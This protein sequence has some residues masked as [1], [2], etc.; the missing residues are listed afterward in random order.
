MNHRVALVTNSLARGGAETQL[1]HLARGLVDRGDE[2]AILS[3]L[4]RVE[5]A[6]IDALRLPVASL[7][8]GSFA[9]GATAVARGT[10]VLQGWA[11]DTVVSFVYQANLLG[12]CAG[13]AARV[14]TIVSSI[15]NERFGGRARDW[16]M[17]ATDPL[18]TVT[19]TNSQF[20]ADRLV[21]RGVVPQRRI[22][23]VPN[24]IDPARYRADPAARERVRSRLGLVD[25]FTWLAVGR[26]EAQKDFV[27]LLRAF[28]VLRAPGPVLLVAGTG[29]ERDALEAIAFE[30]GCGERVRFLGARDDVPELLAAS[31]ALALSSAWEG[32]P[33]VVLEAMVASRPVVAT[34]VGGVR[35]LVEH[36]R[37]GMVV[38]P[39]RPRALASAM[40]ALAGHSPARRAE[41]GAAGAAKAA[42]EHSLGA[43]RAAWLG[44]LDDCGAFR[45]RHRRAAT[46]GALDAP[47]SSAIGERRSMGARA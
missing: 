9:R 38:P 17:R 33:N 26:L 6:E 21:A 37:T 18:A 8:V 15:R 46:R 3:I 10:R 13:R 1:V 41:M 23:V 11:P 34:D 7:G 40:R 19:T 20:A 16:L 28:S 5:L 43:A 44:V 45:R 14:P 35:E 42:R 25:A 27:T 22:A 4:P 47:C 39:R 32:S 36:G 30:L 2:V 29:S 12:R 24:G 31:D